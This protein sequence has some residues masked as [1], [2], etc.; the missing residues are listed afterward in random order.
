MFRDA[1]GGTDRRSGVAVDAELCENRRGLRRDR[2]VSRSTRGDRCW[3]LQ[4][5]YVT[6]E[7]L[8]ILERCCTQP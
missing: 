8:V 3:W 7:A 1:R 6:T 2:R 4:R 5:N